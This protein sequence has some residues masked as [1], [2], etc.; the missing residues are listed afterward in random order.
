MN[1][2]Q[3]IIQYLALQK[4]AEQL[5]K[6]LREVQEKAEQAKQAK[7]GDVDLGALKEYFR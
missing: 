2:V 5:E 3:T 4:R 1:D 7:K 6:E